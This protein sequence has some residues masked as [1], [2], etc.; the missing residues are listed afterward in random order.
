MHTLS[1]NLIYPSD[2]IKLNITFPN[3]HTH[4][5]VYMAI[6]LQILSRYILFAMVTGDGQIK[7]HE[8]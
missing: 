1:S 3:V 7:K 6:S 4:I 2:L 5:Y 8:Y